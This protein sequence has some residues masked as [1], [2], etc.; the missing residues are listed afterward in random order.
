[1]VSR[2]SPPRLP[3][4]TGMVQFSVVR[5]NDLMSIDIGIGDF[6]TAM[7]CQRF[8]RGELRVWAR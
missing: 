8:Q 6:E 1:M 3:T 4:T 5:L 2:K 7:V